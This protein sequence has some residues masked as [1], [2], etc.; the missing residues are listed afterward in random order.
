M[1]FKFWDSLLNY[2]QIADKLFLNVELTMNGHILIKEH[3][4]PNQVF[5]KF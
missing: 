2:I 1:K 3:F 5:G 4:I